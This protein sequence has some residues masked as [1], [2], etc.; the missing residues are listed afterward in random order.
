MYVDAVALLSI[1]WRCLPSD[2]GLKPALRHLSSFVAH[3][4][5][6]SIPQH[7]GLEP[8]QTRC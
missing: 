4:L 5:T 3:V 8:V 2:G 7:G 1:D 6:L